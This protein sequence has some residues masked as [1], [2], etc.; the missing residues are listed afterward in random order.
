[1]SKALCRTLVLPDHLA[2]T[3][4]TRYN[5]VNLRHFEFFADEP[6]FR[7][8]TFYVILSICLAVY[9]AVGVVEV[10]KLDLE[11]SFFLFL[12]L[13]AIWFTPRR[14]S[15]AAIRLSQTRS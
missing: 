13:K 3:P 12:M 4:M 11:D 8:L 9:S 10:H 2:L 14:F 7:L 1:M 5:I 6:N 15:G